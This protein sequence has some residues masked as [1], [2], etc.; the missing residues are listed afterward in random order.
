MK[1]IFLDITNHNTG[2]KIFTRYIFLPV[3]KGTTQQLEKVFSDKFGD[4]LS[5]SKGVS[6]VDADTG[7][8]NT[9][10]WKRICEVVPDLSQSTIFVDAYS[11]YKGLN[12]I[13]AIGKSWSSGFHYI[14]IAKN[15]T[16]T[17][18]TPIDFKYTY[19]GDKVE[20]FSY[21]QIF[22]QGLYTATDT[23][24]EACY[25]LFPHY[26][27][28]GNYYT[29]TVGADYGVGTSYD[30]GGGGSVPVICS[31]GLCSL[32]LGLLSSSG[33]YVKNFSMRFY[34]VE[35]HN[36]YKSITK[37]AKT[38]YGAEDV[39]PNTDPNASGGESNKQGGNGTFDG[40]TDNIGIPD[41]PNESYSATGTGF[42]ELFT[43]T[44][45]QI[46]A[47][48]NY[49]TSNNIADIWNKMFANP[50]DAIL[51]LSI[52]PLTVPS[53]ST[54][55]ILVGNISTGVSANVASK[56]Y[57]KVDCGTLKIEPYW[58]NFLDFSPF[59]KFQIYLPYIG[60]M[61]LNVDDCIGNEIHVE[62]HCDILSGG[63]VAYVKCG[64]HVLYHYSGS[65]STLV[66]IN[67]NDYTNAITS[68]LSAVATIGGVVGSAVA[69]GG[70][71]IPSTLG[72]GLAG[73]NAIISQ[74]PTI[75]RSGSMGGSLGQLGIQ[76]PYI[77]CER[78][79]QSVPSN[80]NQFTGY[81]S[82]I[83]SKLSSL[84]GYTE[85]SEVNFS[86]FGGTDA[87]LTEVLALLKGGVIL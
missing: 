60:V 72:M 70:V 78:P 84:T 39:I 34:G 33:S 76:K 24:S 74:K 18:K 8:F 41:M 81:P 31:D 43:P 65:I 61:D 26:Y 4:E 62:Y 80:M 66:P 2:A 19:D 32:K 1:A 10:N 75:K 30:V 52:V 86:N 15:A 64:N 14:P 50:I 13:D 63:C 28:Y 16:L 54:S 87:E 71:S 6:V 73:A 40:S 38:I 12:T 58:N 51:G 46:K 36:N 47:L 22:S 83:T 68:T 20:T 29:W 48:A 69:T 35:N 27:F 85:I 17:D 7:L 21:K 77:I 5:P 82:N 9:T 49:M 3:Y 44:K 57:L 11:T 45:T 67:T 56:Q 53:S 42:V 59:T 79:K 25:L 55:D 37:I 23:S